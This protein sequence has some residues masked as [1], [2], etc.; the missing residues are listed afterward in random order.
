MQ[1]GS[2]RKRYKRQTCSDVSCAQRTEQARSLTSEAQCLPLSTSEIQ[3]QEIGARARVEPVAPGIAEE[4][5]SKDGG[6]D[7]QGRENNQVRRVKQMAARVIQHSAP[8]GNRSEDS[9]AE[10]AQ[11]GFGEDHAG[12]SDGGLNQDRLENIGQEMAQQN[13]RVRSPQGTRGHDKFQFFYF[14]RL[15]ASQTRIPGPAGHGQRENNF[16][17]ARA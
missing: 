13:P 1:R 17:D 11:R 3:S 2:P 8:T 7:G 14:E 6:H 10:K 15:R 9:D 5:E 4:I 16:S 12:H